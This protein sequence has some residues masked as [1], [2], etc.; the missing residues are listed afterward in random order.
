VDERKCPQ[1]VLLRDEEMAK[2]GPFAKTRYAAGARRGTGRDREAMWAGSAAGAII[3]RS[4]AIRARGMTEV[5]E[6]RRPTSSVD[7][8]GQC[9]RS[10]V[11]SDRSLETLARC[12]ARGP[13]VVVKAGLPPSG[14]AR[15]GVRG[16]RRIFAL[17]PGKGRSRGEMEKYNRS[18][19][20]RRRRGK[21]DKHRSPQHGRA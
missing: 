7:S 3:Q 19:D 6:T 17:F 9:S 14:M 5:K 21:Y 15:A 11:G 12:L 4:R 18:W 8:R 20:I 10:P 2:L 13:A 16:K 1:T